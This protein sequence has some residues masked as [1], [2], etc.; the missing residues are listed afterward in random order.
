MHNL[1]PIKRTIGLYV[2]TALLYFNE[3]AAISLLNGKLLKLVDE[4]IYLGYSILS[5][6][7][8]MNIRIGKVGTVR[9]NLE[10]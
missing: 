7:S 3:D 8:D 4:F 5:A 9:S 10:W 1:K 6:E 2:N